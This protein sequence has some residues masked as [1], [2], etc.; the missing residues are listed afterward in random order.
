ML[1]TPTR[2]RKS[3]SQPSSDNET[4]AGVVSSR[5]PSKSELFTHFPNMSIIMSGVVS[6]LQTHFI[7]HHCGTFTKAIS[8]VLKWFWTIP[9]IVPLIFIKVCR[10]KSHTSLDFTIN[11]QICPSQLFQKKLPRRKCPGSGQRCRQWKGTWS[12]SLHLALSHKKRTAKGVYRLNQNLL[13]TVTG[14][15]WNSMFIIASQPTKTGS[16]LESK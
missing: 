6:G 9:K 11:S 5:C 4:S 16:K 2:K 15:P 14:R 13:K 10:L 1:T 3:P 8:T 12:D 7:N